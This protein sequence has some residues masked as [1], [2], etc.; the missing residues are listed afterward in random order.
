MFLLWMLRALCSRSS[1]RRALKRLRSSAVDFL[2]RANISSLSS[3][4]KGL[5]PS[6]S[7][8]LM[9]VMLEWS[10][11]VFLAVSSMS[12]SI[13]STFPFSI[14]TLEME[15]CDSFLLIPAMAS[16]NLLLNYLLIL[17]FKV[18]AY[19]FFSMLLAASFLVSWRFPLKTLIW[20]TFCFTFVGY[21]IPLFSSLSRESALSD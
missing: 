17:L 14:E 13:F 12:L 21:L 11:A 4:F 6:L 7:L 8:S 5:C 9:S 2:E 1:F 16:R 15:T 18:S 20:K 19:F 3:P 10:S